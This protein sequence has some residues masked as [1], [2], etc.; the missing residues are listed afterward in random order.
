MMT[1]VVSPSLGIFLN[2]WQAF[3]SGGE[4]AQSWRG[5]CF[6]KCQHVRLLSQI[7][8]GKGASKFTRL[9]PLFLQYPFFFN[10]EVLLFLVLFLVPVLASGWS[11]LSPLLL[12]G[13]L[14]PH[15]CGPDKGKSF[16]GAE[17]WGCFA[18]SWWES[19]RWDYLYIYIS[20]NRL[21]VAFK[22]CKSE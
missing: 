5:M 4:Y 10:D 14:G 13:Y 9:I 15:R 19:G 12:F 18:G 20:F 16:E 22:P 2:K 21:E 7:L 1:D 3:A 6:G 8:F 11:Y 17:G